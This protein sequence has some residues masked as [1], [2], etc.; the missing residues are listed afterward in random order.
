MLKKNCNK[1]QN[2][3]MTQRRWDLEQ[4]IAR[5]RFMT[6]PKDIS[7]YDIQASIFSLCYKIPPHLHLK[8]KKQKNQ[9]F[10]YLFF[11]QGKIKKKRKRVKENHLRG[12]SG[13]MDGPGDEDSP[14]SIDENSF[15]IIGNA[16]L[17]QLRTH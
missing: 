16:A 11:L 2:L 8:K 4:Y 15:L 7:V 17:D 9:S 5:R 1:M 3:K 6:I 13:I 14:L 10:F 12:A